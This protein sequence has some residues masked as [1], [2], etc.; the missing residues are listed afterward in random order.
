M[1]KFLVQLKAT[2]INDLFAMNALYRP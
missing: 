2:D 1:R